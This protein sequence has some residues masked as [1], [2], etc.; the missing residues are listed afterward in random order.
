L[1]A[2]DLSGADIEG[3]TL[4]EA[5]TQGAKMPIGKNPAA[6]RPKPT[7]QDATTDFGKMIDKLEDTHGPVIPWNVY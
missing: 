7:F 5:L 2:A 3:V 1:I 6:P 4:T